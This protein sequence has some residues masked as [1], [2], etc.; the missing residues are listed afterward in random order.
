MR[1]E[2]AVRDGDH[3]PPVDGDQRGQLALRQDTPE[4]AGGIGFDRDVDRNAAGF[5]AQERGP[6]LADKPLKLFTRHPRFG[7]A[8]ILHSMKGVRGEHTQNFNGWGKITLF[9]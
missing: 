6:V 1:A 2:F 8:H 4:A 5:T 7:H 3:R 9:A